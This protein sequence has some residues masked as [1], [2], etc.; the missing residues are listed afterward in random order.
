MAGCMRFVAQRLDAL[1]DEP[2]PGVPRTIDAAVVQR[3]CMRT[4]NSG[5]QEVT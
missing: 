1:L 2:R 5:H 4:S 3:F